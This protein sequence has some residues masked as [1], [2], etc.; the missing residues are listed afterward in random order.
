VHSLVS[1]TSSPRPVRIAAAFVSGLVFAAFVYW[2]G[3]TSRAQESARAILVCVGSDRMLR[4]SEVDKPCRP[5]EERFALASPSVE[6]E[7]SK[8][9]EKA[10][11]TPGGIRANLKVQAPF[12]VVDKAGRTILRVDEQVLEGRG[13]AIFSA[14]GRAVSAVLSEGEGFGLVTVRSSGGPE[15]KLF[16]RIAE[17]G[18][19]IHEVNQKRLE[20]T[21]SASGSFGLRAFNAGGT[22]VAT[23]GATGDGFGVGAVGSGGNEPVA[24]IH[25]LGGVGT[26]VVSGPNGQA[27]ASMVDAPQ[28]GKV[29]ISNRDGTMLVEAGTEA[30]RGYVKTGPSAYPSIFPFPI[31]QLVGKR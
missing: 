25:A 30:G 20:V 14:S 21:R 3:A 31:S 18:L 29:E 17:A 27:V 11:V 12:E 7:L 2:L 4:M 6:T 8:L 13:L 23:F 1:V 9:G 10:D 28:G 26:V 16:G 5:H 15:A 19:S 22:R 24:A